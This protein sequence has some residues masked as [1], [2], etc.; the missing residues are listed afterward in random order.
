M[1]SLRSR[2]KRAI[3]LHTP[4]QKGRFALDLVEKAAEGGFARAFTR[5]NTRGALRGCVHCVACGRQVVRHDQ[6]GQGLVVRR[7]TD[8]P[9]SLERQYVCD[10]CATHWLAR[11][12][13]SPQAG[14]PAAKSDAP[15]L[16]SPK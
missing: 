16:V 13:G 11:E 5:E 7:H 6:L 9:D 3:L 4:E 14:K 8:D 10:R 15:A 12:V 1:E 2:N